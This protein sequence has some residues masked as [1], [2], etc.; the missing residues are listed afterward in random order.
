MN[1][2]EIPHSLIQAVYLLNIF[3]IYSFELHTKDLQK[4]L[5]KNILIHIYCE[6]NLPMCY[7]T[8]ISY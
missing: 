4:F 1:N 2:Q 7:N 3:Y 6:K 5:V 8:H